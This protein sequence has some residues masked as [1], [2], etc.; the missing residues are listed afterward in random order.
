MKDLNLV[1]C[2]VKAD[3]AKDRLIELFESS[4]RRGEGESACRR[5]AIEWMDGLLERNE[6]CRRVDSTQLAQRYRYWPARTEVVSPQDYLSFFINDVAANSTNVA[7]RL[8]LSHMSAATPL[9]SGMI[10]EC[11]AVLNQNLS[12]R[13]ASP[14]ASVLE[15]EVLARL[16]QAVYDRPCAF[17]DHHLQDMEHVFGMV[18]CGGTVSNIAALWCARNRAF[19]ETDQ[20]GGIEAEG[21]AAG[22]VE[23]GYYGAR[24]LVSKLHHYSIHKAA[25]LFGLGTS[26]VV[27]VDVDSGGRMDVGALRRA[28]EECRRAKHCVLAIVG[29]AGTTE[30]G[31]VD[32]LDEIGDLAA[33]YGVH[34]HVDAAWG[35]PM[36]FSK[37]HGELLKGIEK[38]QTVTM[39]GHKQFYLPVG[40]SMLLFRDTALARAITKTAAYM[41]REGSGDLGRVS[42]EGSRPAVSVLLHANLCVIGETG[43]GEIVDRNIAMAMRMARII[44][45]EYDDFELLVEP[46]TNIV[47]YRYAPDRVRLLTSQCVNELN[48][49]LHEQQVEDGRTLV[50]R[51]TL[52]DL[53]GY[54]GVPLVVQRAVVH[55]IRT[56]EADLRTVLDDQRRIAQ[57]LQVEMR[58]VECE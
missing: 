25:G 5:M 27:G 34:F 39:D 14:S 26:S 48:T 24:I 2:A 19:P 17:Y 29:T 37:R 36:L 10:A 42:L 16:H 4:P 40:C 46:A 21:L 33:E 49:R 56:S 15:R 32:P 47:V 31:S 55:N 54:R 52:N 12:K 23:H 1:N 58:E 43:Y 45:E 44:E 11:V 13:E 30:L 6:V 57:S 50:S 8:C 3:N 7:S 53:P 18:T 51:T 9:F 35:G 20:F 22:L 38:A 41:L 28:I